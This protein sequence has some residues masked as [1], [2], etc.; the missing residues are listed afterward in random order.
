MPKATV[1]HH[2]D[3][4]RRKREVGRADY[5]QVPAPSTQACITQDGHHTPFGRRIATALY[6]S[7]GGRS[8]GGRHERAY[9][10]YM[11]EARS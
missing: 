6:R 10:F 9:R 8:L 4:L 2:S 3:T 1:N 5:L 7:H 11:V